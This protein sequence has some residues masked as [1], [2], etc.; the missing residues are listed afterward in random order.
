MNIPKF[1]LIVY[2]VWAT[3][4]AAAIG[5]LVYGRWSLAFVSVATL[6]A[7]VLPA[8]IAR[9]YHIHIPWAFFTGIVLFIFGSLFLG[10]A[11]D[12]YNLYWWWDVVLHGASAIGFGLIGFIFMFYLFQ[13]DRYAAPAWAVAFFSYCF[14]MMIGALW[15]IFEFSMDQIFGTNISTTHSK[16]LR[17]CSNPF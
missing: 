2:L 1:G 5:S 16:G 17:R 4:V 3:L 7:S 9:L 6:V 12:F 8:L 10:E 11:L 14:A 13:G 15:E